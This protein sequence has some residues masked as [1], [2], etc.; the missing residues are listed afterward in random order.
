MQYMLEVVCGDLFETGYAP[1]TVSHMISGHA[2]TRAFCGHLFASFAVLSV[3]LLE[4]EMVL[5]DHE[6][7]VSNLLSCVSDPSEVQ[8]CETV[9]SLME[10]ISN[11]IKENAHDSRT[12]KL[13]KSYLFLC[14]LL[15]LFLFAERTGDFVLL[16]TAWISLSQYSMQQGI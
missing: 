11:L 1:G 14:H 8:N 12:V 10:V 15:R 16:Y 9:H 3:L 13:W 5:Q 6:V 4:G 7:L 2:Y